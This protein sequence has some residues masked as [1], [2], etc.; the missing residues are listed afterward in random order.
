VGGDPGVGVGRDVHFPQGEG[1]GKAAQ[2]V[3]KK[4]IRFEMARF[5]T[6]TVGVLGAVPS[7]AV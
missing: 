1:S 6:R 4:K 2:S 3:F 5:Q 7:A